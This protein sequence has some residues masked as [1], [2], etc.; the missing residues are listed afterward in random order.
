MPRIQIVQKHNTAARRIL[1]RGHNGKLYPYLLLVNDTCLSDARREE[2]VLQLMRLLNHYLSR[3]KETAK[4]FLCFTVPRVVAISPQVRLVQ[5]NPNSISLMDIYK[6]RCSRLGVDPD[7]PIAK[8]YDRLAVVQSSS[9]S[10]TIPHHVL[11][12]ILMEIE[13]DVVP[14]TLLKDWAEQTF[15]QATDLWTFRKQLTLQMA[16]IATAEYSMNLTRLN[17]DMLYIHMDSGLVNVSYFRFDCENETDA[18]PVPF[19]L[20]H[21][22]SE[23]VTSIG[24]AGPMTASIIAAA[25]CFTHPNFQLQSILRTI[26]RDEVMAWTGSRA[27]TEGD[28]EKTSPSGQ[29][30]AEALVQTVNKCV[31]GIMNRMQSLTVFTGSESEAG[32]LV[33]AANSYDNL[34]RTD[35]AWHPWL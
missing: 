22:M 20:T 13:K 21:N 34:C 25:R 35:P 18:R 33:A 30:T 24:V 26:L 4:R 16:L 10:N 7:A 27:V 8:Y 5:D 2:R 12:D 29:M 1:I 14:S 23:F 11:R 19:R 9:T 6:E 32:K 17:P 31:A 15:T 3:Q 28:Q